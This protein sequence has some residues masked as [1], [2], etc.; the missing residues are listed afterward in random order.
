VGCSGP[1]LAGPSVP[2]GRVTAWSSL[3]GSRH[4]LLRHRLLCSCPPATASSAPARPP[5]P[6]LLVGRLCPPPRRNVLHRCGAM[7]ASRE[8]RRAAPRSSFAAGR[9]R[10]KLLPGVAVRAVA[11]CGSCGSDGGRAGVRTYLEKQSSF[12]L[13]RFLSFLRASFFV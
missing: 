11:R 10:G 2:A 8:W 9:G 13:M 5:S 3:A 6:P 1:E 12:F 7:F 4:L